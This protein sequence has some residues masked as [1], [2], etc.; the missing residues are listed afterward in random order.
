MR[1]FA[2]VVLERRTRHQGSFCT[3]PFETA[4]ASEA[5]FF[6]AVEEFDAAEMRVRVQ[7]SPDG[8]HWVDEGTDF[9]PISSTGLTSCRVSHFGGWLRLACDLEEGGKVRVLIHLILKE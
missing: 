6:L 9:A 3:E 1:Q 7:I 2:Q 4:W 8:I 5:I